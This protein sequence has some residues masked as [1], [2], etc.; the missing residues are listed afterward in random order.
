MALGNDSAIAQNEGLGDETPAQETASQTATP[1]AEATQVL[2]DVDN[3]EDDD[4]ES[5]SDDSDDA[6]EP[7]NTPYV[8]VP[9][10]CNFG[11]RYPMLSGDDKSPFPHPYTTDAWGDVYTT[12]VCLEEQGVNGASEAIRQKPEWWR[13]IDDETIVA[14]WKTEM[15]EQG[16]REPWADYVIKELKEVY[17]PISA[18]FEHKAGP[19][20]TREIMQGDGLVSEDT[21]TKLKTVVKE[22]LEDEGEPDWHPGSNEQVLDLV[23][24]SLF[25]IVYEKTRVLQSDQ[26]DLK[27]ELGTTEGLFPSLDKCIKAP[28]YDCK[29]DANKN[30]IADYAI[31][32]KYQWI[33]TPFKIDENGKVSVQSYINNLHPIWHK[34]LYPLIGQI[35]EDCVPALEHTLGAF[36]SGQLRRINP[37][38]H[39]N[40]YYSDEEPNFEDENGEWDDTLWEEWNE[41]RVPAIN[42][43]P[44]EVVQMTKEFE[45]KGKTLNVITKLANIHLTP[46]NPSYPGGTWHVEGTIN[47]NIV[48][49]VLYYYDVENISESRLA[50]RTAISDP[51]YEQSDERGVRMVFGIEDEQKMVMEL[52]NVEAKEDRVVVF[53][54]IYQHQVQPFEL[55]DKTKPG[56]R[57][58]VCFF[59][60]D[61]HDKKVHTTARVPPQ[62]SAWWGEKVRSIGLLDKL[63]DELFN[64]VLDAHDDYPWSLQAAKEVRLDLMEERG[65]VVEDQNEEEFDGPLFG[66][67]FSLCE[68]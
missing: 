7:T 32:K 63:P 59:I 57:K 51:E 40:G 52:G 23:H 54:N 9:Q 50:F 42:N 12:P 48:A 17:R 3:D 41:N 16:V 8:Y 14:K 24:P 56:H 11:E 2:L 45:A 55:A 5:G 68:H 10:N 44:E 64:K 6:E 66:R 43:P 27:F 67:Q 61:P 33:P 39:S 26:P 62:N 37:M 21:K 4:D 49:T 47:E 22:L 53:P 25:P 20:L 18:K 15:V 30:D 13:K 29:T 36:L 38:S 34:D 1:N 28:V 46:E 65:K 31:S 19:I 60:C 58:I 35:F